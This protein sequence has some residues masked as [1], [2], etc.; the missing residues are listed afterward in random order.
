MSK[1][2][3]SRFTHWI[4]PYSS[5][6]LAIVAGIG[7]SSYCKFIDTIDAQPAFKPIVLYEFRVEPSEIP[8]QGAAMLYTPLCNT[9]NKTYSPIVEVGVQQSPVR[10]DA[11]LE[12]R[13]RL[14]TFTVTIPGNT[15][16]ITEPIPIPA[17][18]ELITAG[19]WFGY[20]QIEVRGETSNQTQTFSALSN[21]F[22]V[23]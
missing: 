3:W 20:V 6:I 12:G 19:E 22:R 14:R 11:S 21:I 1:S 2:V 17:L 15:C 23:Y 8:F 4:G 16:P 10:I 9:S 13:I 7:I 18:P 5:L